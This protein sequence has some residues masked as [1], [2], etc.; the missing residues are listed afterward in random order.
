M[1]MEVDL[2]QE[3]IQEETREETKE[4]PK[5][6]EEEKSQKE[7][8]VEP[9]SPPRRQMRKRTRDMVAEAENSSAKNSP[10]KLRDRPQKTTVET[11]SSPKKSVRQK[12]PKP[13]KENSV[14]SKSNTSWV[15]KQGVAKLSQCNSNKG[16]GGK[17]NTQLQRIALI[18]TKLDNVLKEKFTS[19]DLVAEENSNKIFE[20]FE[21]LSTSE[22]DVRTLLITGICKSLHKFQRYWKQKYK[23]YREK[24]YDPGYQLTS[25]DKKSMD[26]LWLKTLRKIVEQSKRL[27]HRFKELINEYFFDYNVDFE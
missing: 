1:D 26:E 13:V 21:M 7:E 19:V 2:P 6:V 23:R 15:K 18:R 17:Q 12:P 5:V 20:D 16:K 25:A 9:E 3:E 4:E 10:R 11:H 8:K 22:I 14:S 24:K 27:L